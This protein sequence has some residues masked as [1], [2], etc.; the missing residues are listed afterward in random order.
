MP[1]HRAGIAREH[2]GRGREGLSLD[3]TYAHHE[4]GPQ[5]WGINKAWDHVAQR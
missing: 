1:R 4:R 5:I 2:H 3:G